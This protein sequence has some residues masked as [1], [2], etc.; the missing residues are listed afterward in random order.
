MGADHIQDFGG[1]PARYQHFLYLGRGF[2][3][4]FDGV[5][6]RILEHV[7][8]LSGT[9][10]V[11]HGRF[12]AGEQSLSGAADAAAKNWDSLWQAAVHWFS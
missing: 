11:A 10:S 5:M 7:F 8:G 6:G 12:Q 2:I 9:V 4:N 3:G 1:Q